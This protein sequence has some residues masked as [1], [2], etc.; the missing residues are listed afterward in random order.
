VFATLESGQAYVPNWHFEAI[1]YQPE[2]VSPRQDQAPD[3][4]HASA[5][6]EVGNRVGR[7]SGLRP[8]HDPTRRIICVSYSGDLAKKHAN[9]FRAVLQAPWYQTLFPRTRIGQKDSESEIELTVRGLRL[10]TSIGG[11]LTG[12]GGDLIIIDDPLKPDDGYSETKRNAANEWFKNTL[13]SRLDDKRTGAIVIVMQRVHMDDR[14]QLMAA[15]LLRS[16]CRRP[17]ILQHDIDQR[18]EQRR[19]FGWIKADQPQCVFEVGE[20]LLGGQ[21]CAEALAAPF[22]DRMQRSVLRQLRRRPLDPGVRGLAEA[23]VKLLHQ[24]RLGQARLTDNQRE[25]ALDFAGAIPARSR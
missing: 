8:W 24:P 23:A 7:V 14:R 9:D 17:V 5:L 4:Q 21:V 1:A 10:A 15:Q 18:R 13:L 16:Q 11:T 20:T 2:R 22:G 25:L 19:I 6:A 3:H 12:R